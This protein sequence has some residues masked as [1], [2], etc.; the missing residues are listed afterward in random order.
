M[1]ADEAGPTR[2]RLTLVEDSSL[3]PRAVWNSVSPHSSPPAR[4]EGSVWD[5][6]PAP[7]LRLW[8]GNGPSVQLFC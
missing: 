5:P 6:L 4:A 1:C 3:A 7:H 8:S 2:A